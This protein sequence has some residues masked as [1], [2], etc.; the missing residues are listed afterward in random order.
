M[1]ATIT[2]CPPRKGETRGDSPGKPGVR[3]CGRKWQRAVSPVASASL[4]QAHPSRCPVIVAQWCS[5][6]RRSLQPQDGRGTLF[7]ALVSQ[8][9]R[10][11]YLKMLHEV[12]ACL[13]HLNVKRGRVS[14]SNCHRRS[15]L[16]AARYEVLDRERSGKSPVGL[17]APSQ[18]QTR[19]FSPCFLYCTC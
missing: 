17:S 19:V 8:F 12:A 9:W 10:I 14:K 1:W 13:H 5:A 6:H 15:P 11:G 3:A 4:K 16:C 7:A 18:Q 2:R